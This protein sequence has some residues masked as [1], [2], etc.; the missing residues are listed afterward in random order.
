MMYKAGDQ[1]CSCTLLQKCGEGGYGE[2]WL[3]ETAIGDKVAL[4]ILKEKFS[5]RELEGLRNYKNCNHPNLLKIRHVEITE[6]L[7]CY[8]MDAADDLNCGNGEYEPDTLAKRL[9][10]YGRLDGKEIMTMLESLLAGLEELHNHGLVHRDIKPDNIL[11]VNGRA[12]LSDAGLIAPAGKHTL[13]GSPGFISPR[14]LEF[15]MRYTSISTGFMVGCTSLR[16]G[17]LYSM[18]VVWL[19][20]LYQACGAPSFHP[21]MQGS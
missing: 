3:A 15:L 18:T 12:T 4:K 1:L 16:F 20:S 7:V 2:V 9:N 17:L 10:R 5:G 6:Q 11:Y 14:L 19:R 13:V 21:R 8:T